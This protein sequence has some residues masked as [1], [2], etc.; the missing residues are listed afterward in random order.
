MIKEVDPKYTRCTQI[1]DDKESPLEWLLMAL[2][3]K[4]DRVSFP[5]DCHPIPL[6]R[7]YAVFARV[8]LPFE[9]LRKLL[10]DK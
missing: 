5:C 4:R 7:F 2:N 9:C 1:S 10:R 3:Y 8:R 6:S